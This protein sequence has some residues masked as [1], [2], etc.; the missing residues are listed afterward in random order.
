MKT[1]ERLIYSWLLLAPAM[2]CTP[3]QAAAQALADSIYRGGPILTMNDSASRVEA[4][5]VK[6][7]RILSTGTLADVQAHIGE[8]TRV[9]DL[10]GRALLPGWRFPTRT[11]KR[12]TE[13]RKRRPNTPSAAAKSPGKCC[14]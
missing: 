4:V 1:R 10:D 11:P 12:L 3:L 8:Q 5:A 6:G 7:G 14:L 9:V 13:P 2:L